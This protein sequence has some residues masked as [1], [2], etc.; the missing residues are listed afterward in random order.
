M[1]PPITLSPD[2][3]RAM[4]LPGD[5]SE[6]LLWRHLSPPTV[7][8]H[9]DAEG[10]ADLRDALDGSHDV[11]LD[12]TEHGLRVTPATECSTA[13]PQPADVIVGQ[14]ASARLLCGVLDALP[15]GPVAIV[16]RRRLDPITV[17]AV[18]GPAGLRDA[19]VMPRRSCALMSGTSRPAEGCPCRDC[20]AG[21]RWGWGW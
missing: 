4:C 7:T 14:L 10:R 11:Y 2:E 19:M 5:A 15:R 16:W 9:L 20:T 17:H 6:H 12:A 21:R 3:R 18:E 8:V 1:S 13:A